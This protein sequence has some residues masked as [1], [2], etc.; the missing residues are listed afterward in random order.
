MPDYYHA[1]ALILCLLLLPAFDYLYHRYRDT[2]TLLWFLG[3]IFA[4]VSMVLLY[5]T[6]AWNLLGATPPWQ[7]ACG[8][9]ALLISTALFLGSLSPLS[10]RVGRRRILYVVPYTVTLVIASILFYGVFHGVSPRGPLFLVFPALAVAALLIAILW[11]T[12]K[13]VLPSGLGIAFCLILGLPI[14]WAC[15]R[16]GVNWA[17]VFV[18]S[19]NLVMT[20]ILIVA[21]SR[22]FTPGVILSVFGFSAWS[23]SALEY[24]HFLRHNPA[25]EL[26]L[27]HIAVFGKVVAAIGMI[28]LA[29]ENELAINEAAQERER[30]ARLEL[31][32]YTSIIL[33]R[34]RVEDFD[35]QGGE[36]CQ[37]IVMHSRFGQAALLLESDGRYRLAGTAGLDPAVVAGLAELAARIPAAEFLAPGSAPSAVE[38]SLTL[39]LDLAPWL[40][41]GDDLAHLRFTSVLAVPMRGRVATEGA[42][43]LAGMRPIEGHEHRRFDQP[44]RPD[45][46]LPI[47]MLTAR[48]QANRS[49]TI[50]LEKLIDSEKFAGLGQLADNVT[51]QLN[52]PLT[53][54]LGYATLLEETRNLNAQERKGIE[55]ILTEARRMHSTLES[56]ARISRPHGA[57]MS[58]VSVA[59][60]LADMEQ[61]HRP[62]FLQR[63]IE[64]QLRLA[65]ALPSVL[66]NAQQLR[67][68]VLH[69]LQYAMDAV[70]KQAQ[71]PR[72]PTS[73]GPSV[74]KPA[75]RASRCRFS[76][77]T[78]ASDSSIRTAPSI[79][80]PPPRP[81]ARPP[82][83]AS[84]SAPPFS[85][86]TTAAPPPSTSSRRAPPSSSS[87]R[88]PEPPRAARLP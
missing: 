88:P 30:R 61:L 44:L 4:L 80:S 78:P 53:V 27:I 33:S 38:R 10:F 67:Q 73:P 37:T 68:A 3:F 31:E 1:P 12:E 26:I 79:P 87:S 74:S 42:L 71:D 29:L 16:I 20:A 35:R 62:D 52:N 84:V 24:L 18:A 23:L 9:T 85:A 48:I 32:A 21:A 46:L 56:L 66:C 39:Q 45:D 22:R 6:G 51:Q 60:L 63:S 59:E 17:L 64:F 77:A 25:L 65:P 7:V 14:L 13:G 55:S 83:S 19:A 50:M 70:D 15:Y 86:T 43:L 82:A 5:S 34:R 47:E 36:I 69:C 81:A 8:Q 40:R 57:Q 28:L 72:P 41:P 54:I 2:R 75:A 58:A 49:Q 76:S 11:N